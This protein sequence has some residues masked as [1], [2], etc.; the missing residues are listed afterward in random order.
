MPELDPT[1]PLCTV[2]KNNH[3]AHAPCPQGKPTSFE[4]RRSGPDRRVDTQRVI[5]AAKTCYLMLMSDEEGPPLQ[6]AIDE[7]GAAFGQPPEEIP[8]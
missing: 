2:C 1:D 4:D 5:D 7:L 8:A 3:P 6:A